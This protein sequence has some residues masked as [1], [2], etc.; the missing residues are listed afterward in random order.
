MRGARWLD[1]DGPLVRLGISTAWPSVMRRAPPAP[2]PPVRTLILLA[3]PYRPHD[4]LRAV[5]AM[6][7]TSAMDA[8]N[9]ASAASAL[10]RQALC[11]RF[12]RVVL[13][14]SANIADG[15]SRNRERFGH[16]GRFFR[17][18]RS[19]I[20]LNLSQTFAHQ[21]GRGSDVR[22]SVR[23]C[24]K[25]SRISSS[26]SHASARLIACVSSSRAL[27]DA[28]LKC[29]RAGARAPQAITHQELCLALRFFDLP[30]EPESS[31]IGACAPQTLVRVSVRLPCASRTLACACRQC[32]TLVSPAMPRAGSRTIP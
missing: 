27:G 19:R 24:L 11:L 25:R 10:A 32:P 28:S 9:T 7:A 15:T 2:T 17:L 13:F 14:A 3:G 20:S 8:T 23:I 12:R 4:R 31:R 18:K 6:R 16:L 1:T 26:A 29:S 21:L 30:V 22:A 5:S